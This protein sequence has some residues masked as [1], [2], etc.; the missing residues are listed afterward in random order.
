MQENFLWDVCCVTD[1]GGN[2]NLGGAPVVQRQVTAP[3]NADTFRI[4]QEHQAP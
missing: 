2:W 3:F 1:A 4:T